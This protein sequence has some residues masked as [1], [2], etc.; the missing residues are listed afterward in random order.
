MK[1]LL[2]ILLCLPFI[3]FASFPINT[4]ISSNKCDTIILKNGDE[5]LVNIIEIR[6][7]QIAYEKC[8]NEKKV[9]RTIYKE[10]VLMIKYSDGTNEIIKSSKADSTISSYGGSLLSILLFMTIVALIILWLRFLSL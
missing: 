6:P 8:N 5:I 4:N 2:L 9:L 10:D 1:K 3:G 7:S